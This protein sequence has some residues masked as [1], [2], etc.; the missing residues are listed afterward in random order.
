M[1][2]TQPPAKDS[3]HEPKKARMEIQSALS[4]LDE[5]KVRTIQPHDDTLMV[6]LR[7]GEY[8]MKRV[9]VDQDSGAEIMYPDLYK[10]L[11]LKPEDLTGYD[12]PLLG[13]DRKMVIPKG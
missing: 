11:N 8:D 5:D 1:S 12:S 2:V 9:L 10:G 7:I 4:F 3:N 6:T 13:F